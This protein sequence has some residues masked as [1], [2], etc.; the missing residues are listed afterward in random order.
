M[1]TENDLSG[2]VGVDP[3]YRNYANESHRPYLTDEERAHMKAHGQLTD[4]EAL[5]AAEAANAEVEVDEPVVV[6]EP[7]G[8]DDLITPTL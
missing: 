1:A 4:M 6:T 5:A 3:E 8:D 2:Y 7:E